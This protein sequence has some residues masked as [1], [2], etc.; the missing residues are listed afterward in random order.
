[1]NRRSL[2]SLVGACALTLW[3]EETKPA[4]AAAQ[5][6]TDNVSFPIDL[7]ESIPCANGG[8]GEDVHLTGEIHSLFHITIDNQGG[9]HVKTHSNPQGVRGVGLTTGDKYQ[10]TGVTQDHFNGKVGQTF[11]FI[12]NFRII[13]QGPNNNVLLHQNVH[14]TVS[15]KGDV[16]AS[17]D[18]FSAEC[19]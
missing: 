13:G 18:N 6:F 19:R 8:A 16:T 9:V 3:L 2:L 15:A 5:T 1:M 10:G 11:T 14:F 4:Q 17:V 7:I 12:N